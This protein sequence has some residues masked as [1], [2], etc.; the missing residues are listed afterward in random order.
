MT[1][2]RGNIRRRDRAA[3]GSPLLGGVNFKFEGDRG[4]TGD[5][6]LRYGGVGKV[7]ARVVGKATNI[8]K[9]VKG[10]SESSG[11]QLPRVR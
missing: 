11:G 3:A 4:P 8:A 2:C 1:N 7:R 10:G 6:R 5:Y 9:I